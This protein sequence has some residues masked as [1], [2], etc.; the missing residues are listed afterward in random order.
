MRSTS[1]CFGWPLIGIVAVAPGL[2]SAQT[3]EVFVRGDL[4]RPVGRD[5]SVGSSV[6]DKDRLQSPGLTTAEVLRGQPGIQVTDSGGIGA[7]A[8]ASV[9]GA[10]SAQ[11]PIYLGG[12]RINDDVGGTADLSL[13]PPALLRRVEIYRSNAPLHADRAS[14]GGAIF[15]DPLRPNEIV[16]S[17]GVTVGSFGYRSAW[18]RSGLG[19]EASSAAVSVRHED[20]DNDY[21]Y[22]DDA[23]MR[24]VHA[25]EG[26]ERRRNAAVQ[27]TDLWVLG[28]T[29]LGSNGHVDLMFNGVTRSQGLPGLGVLPTDRANAQQSRELAS[30]AVTAPCAVE[31]CRVTATTALVRSRM[32]TH[33]PAR[34]LGL[35]ARRVEAEAARVDEAIL[36]ELP[37]ARNMAIGSS[38]RA[39]GERLAIVR[40]QTRMRRAHRV[41]LGATV[42][43]EWSPLTVLR[44][45]ALPGIT[46]DSTRADVAQ[47]EGTRPGS[48]EN[49]CA[50]LPSLRAGAELGS[51]TAMLLFNVAR[52]GRVPTLGERYGVSG[53]V[54]GNELLRPEHAD[55]VELGLRLGSSSLAIDLFAFARRATDLI[56]YVRSAPGYIAPYNVGRA[57]VEGVESM[58]AW[59]PFAFARVD[60]SASVLDARDG[61]SARS[62]HN[63][64]LP[65]HSRLT[66]S[67]RVSLTAKRW[68]ALGIGR[69]MIGIGHLY[70][71]SRY[72]D[73]AGLVVIPEQ[74]SVDVDGSLEAVSG[75]LVVRGRIANVLDQARFDVVGFPLSGRA[76]YTSTEVRW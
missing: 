51:R 57:T 53:S 68:R 25:S 37:V 32:E 4:L 35:G 44:I 42:L 47:P 23:G 45:R 28:T 24:L 5:A 27:T 20:V 58:A 48:S 10:T 60:V 75:R 15:F 17:A 31:R 33:D 1:T 64:V 61:S 56:R 7:L 54:R 3:S 36:V 67:Q 19:T 50:T 29:T 9:R 34:E 59:M 41:T 40:D 8:T 2:A 38:L 21:E 16:P 49:G 18:V 39:A 70:Q 55:S 43:A 63:D 71:S 52:A 65:F 13:V 74:G 30:A 66:I 72:A 14:I 12:V 73:A 76:F 46:C 62:T 26:T 69:S 22:R 6:I 11:T